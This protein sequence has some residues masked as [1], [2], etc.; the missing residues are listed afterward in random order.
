MRKNET[1]I[2]KI[3]KNLRNL[4]PYLGTLLVAAGIIGLLF[5]QKPLQTSQDIRKE[6]A[7]DKTVTWP[8]ITSELRVPLVENKTGELAFHLNNG[9][10]TFRKIYAVFSLSN[11]DLDTP[12][13][14]V[15]DGSGFEAEKIDVEKTT[16]GYLVSVV[17]VPHNLN[18]FTEPTD[19]SLIKV[20]LVPKKAGTLVLNFD[21]DR[22][23]G[24]TFGPAILIHVPGEIKYD[25][26]GTTPPPTSPP[27]TSPPPVIQGCNETCSSNAGCQVGMRCYTVDGENRCRLATNPTSSSCQSSNNDQE[28]QRSCNQYCAS[29][30]ECTTGLTCWNSFC[31]NPEN[32][33]DNRCANPTSQQA[34]LT[35]NGCSEKCST[36]ADCAINLRCYEGECR[37]ATNP[38]STSCSAVTKQTVSTAYLNKATDDITSEELADSDTPAKKGDT[39]VPPNENEI[40][41]INQENA[42]TE[43]ITADDTI[44]PDETI[45]GLLRS[46]ISNSESKLPLFVM[47]LGVMLLIL[48]ILAASVSRLKKPKQFIAHRPDAKDQ[49][50]DIKTFDVKPGNSQ[51]KELL[52]TLENKQKD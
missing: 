39:L 9:G 37:L 52:K 23:Y 32:P 4:I 38:S 22:T 18:W 45:L 42:L 25:I 13:I 47:L 30:A 10:Y 6:A 36:N 44:Q 41:Y 31:R 26:T 20:K 34:A 16:D 1:T 7:E 5:I 8:N 35:I 48:S 2:S 24:E 11:K 3:K 49:R 51:T 50:I 19:K 40:K 15:N 43:R 17:A 14:L 27:P 29:N 28:I 21:Q 12:E 33:E 46:L